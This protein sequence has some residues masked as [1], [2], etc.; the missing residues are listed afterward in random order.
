MTVSSRTPEGFPERCVLCGAVTRLEFSGPA[1][2][3]PCPNCGCLV[4]KS[5]QLLDQFQ[6]RF[7]DHLFLTRDEISPEMSLAAFDI[8]SMEVVELVMQFEDT[9]GVSI[10]DEDYDRLRTIGDVIRY[11]QQRQND[12]G[13]DRPPSGDD[14]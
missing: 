4:W 12:R 2:D 6:T 10:P 9:F 3:A 11:I 5:A 7:G 1:G 8:D 14:Q 13:E